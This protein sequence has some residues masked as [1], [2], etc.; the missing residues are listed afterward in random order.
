MNYPVWD[1]QSS[2]LVIAVIA[3]ILG[4]LVTLL[5]TSSLAV[6]LLVISFVQHDVIALPLAF[7]LVLGANLGSAGLPLL[8]TLRSE[9]EARRVPLG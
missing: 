6:V 4:A 8:A 3:V 5:S 1:L 9:P 7:A 2:G